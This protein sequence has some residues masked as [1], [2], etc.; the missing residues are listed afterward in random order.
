M[1]IK[2]LKRNSEAIRQNFVVMGDKVVTKADCSFLIPYNYLTYKLA[3]TGERL[4]IAAVF[5]VVVGQEYGV[6]NACAQI[7]IT[8][9]ETNQIKILGEEFIEFKFVKG[10]SVVETTEIVK[11]GDLLYE[12][13]KYFY[14][15]GRVPWFMSDTDVAKIFMMHK[16]YGGLNISPNNIPFEIVTS[17]ICRDPKDK[18]KYY[19]HG[20]MKGN[21]IVVP[22]NSVLFNATNTTA[23]LLGNYLSDGVTS[24]LLSP[25]D[26]VETPE[27]LLRS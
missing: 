22:F 14:S 13:N 24:A 21:P 6:M 23:K 26:T 25:S 4:Y 27:L 16:E 18:F 8:P 19:R 1:D 20:E 17:R 15:Y 7:H 3:K 10:Q 5:A 9:N 11:N 12:M 2:N